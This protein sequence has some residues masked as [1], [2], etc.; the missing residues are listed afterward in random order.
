MLEF[1]SI[2]PAS[3][4]PGVLAVQL[5]T[6]VFGHRSCRIPTEVQRQLLKGHD[7]LEATPN[8]PANTWMVSCTWPAARVRLAG[9]KGHHAKLHD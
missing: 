4:F 8:P 1:A 6:A 9:P 2:A 5:Y 3:H 7:G